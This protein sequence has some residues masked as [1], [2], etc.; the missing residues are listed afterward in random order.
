MDGENTG[1]DL[2]DGEKHGRNIDGEAS[3]GE[4]GVELIVISKSSF[5]TALVGEQ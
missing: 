5:D 4:E 3:V 1:H 2:R